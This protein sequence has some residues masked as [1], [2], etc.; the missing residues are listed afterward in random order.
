[1]QFLS[2]EDIV[3]LRLQRHA[4][5]IPP[6]VASPEEDRF[7]EPARPSPAPSPRRE[8]I[9]GPAELGEETLPAGP[10]E[11]KRRREGRGRTGRGRREAVETAEPTNGGLSAP[12]EAVPAERAPAPAREPRRAG[13]P[14]E[15]APERAPDE[16]RAEPK[17][18]PAGQVAAAEPPSE[19]RLE[20]GHGYLPEG[21][22]KLGINEPLLRALRHAG[23]EAPTE[24]QE[25]AIPEALKGRDIV[26]QAKTGTGKT[27]AFGLPTLQRILHGEIRA[28]IV[29]APTRELALQVRDEIE[30]YASYS[31]V[32]AIAVYGGQP[33]EGQR[34]QIASGA[35]VI[36]GT[37]GRI[38]DMAKRA[39]LDLAKFDVVVLDECDRMFD[40]GFRPDIER[41]LA[42]LTSMKQLLLFSATINEDV[43]RLTARYQKDA[44]RLKTIPET[45]TVDNV[46]QRFY[47]V[48]KDRKRS[49]LLELIKRLNPPQAIVF[50]RTKIGCEKLAKAINDQ[51]VKAAELHGD[52]RQERREKILQKFR[53]REI[54][55]LI[56][57][58]VAARG[59]DISSV[60]HVFNYDIPEYAEDYVHRIGRTARMGAKGMA[61]T[62]V[63]PGQGHLLTEVEKLTNVLVHENKLDGFDS[64]LDA[65]AAQLA[66]K[67]RATGT[68][69]VLFSTWKPG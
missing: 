63:E 39:W 25:V 12:S 22:A 3:R 21:F 46:E 50:V 30:R 64:G 13:P 19:A 2:I 57:T 35:Q 5:G 44:V 15:P 52:L 33:L 42:R 24:I 66:K 11:H 68:G 9:A 23:F 67:P 32:R 40:L 16:V 37:P 48:A 8:R 31:K 55:L 43:E 61:V 51:G 49:V 27:A 14:V 18:P 28:A 1:M 38:L 54:A 20:R 17:D 10:L 56:A 4:N 26:G 6:E 65:M 53:D 7:V 34:K 60:T 45:M 62:L 47:T 41:I 58:D 36:V 69:E 29:L 59:L